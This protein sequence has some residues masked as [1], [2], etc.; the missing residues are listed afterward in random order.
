MN[1]IRN[2]LLY[3]DL[4]M[5][6]ESKEEKESYFIMLLE[7]FFYDIEEQ[8][9]DINYKREQLEQNKELLKHIIKENNLEDQMTF[10]KL[11]ENE[12]E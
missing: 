10:K 8:L 12:G 6:K 7:R 2:E 11:I 9:Q 4:I 5:N 1:E 3:I